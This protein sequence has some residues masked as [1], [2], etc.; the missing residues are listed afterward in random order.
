MDS[1]WRLTIFCAA[2]FIGSTYASYCGEG[3]V[4]IFRIGDIALKNVFYDYYCNMNMLNNIRY[5]QWHF[6]ISI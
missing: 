6:Q 1:I 3:Q 4:F 5:G 2:I